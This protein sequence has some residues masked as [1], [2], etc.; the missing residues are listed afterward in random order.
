MVGPAG[1]RQDFGLLLERAVPEQLGPVV[2]FGQILI[3]LS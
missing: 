1:P 2:E 3:V